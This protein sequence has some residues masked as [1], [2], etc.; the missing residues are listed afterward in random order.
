MEEPWVKAYAGGVPRHLD[1]EKVA[2]PQALS[3]TASQFP[4]LPALIFLDSKIQYRQLNEMATRFANA[5]VDFGVKRG[6]RVAML[7]PNMPQLVAATYGAW[8]MGAVVVMNNPLYTDSELEYQFRNSESTVLV[9][10]DL[11][12][13]RMIRLR[14]ETPIRKIIVAH[15]RDHLKFPKKQLLPI[16][17]R[18]KHRNI[19]PQENVHEW[20]DLMKR[21]PALEP[22]GEVDFEEL[23]CLQYTGGTTGV[24]KGVMLTHANLSLNTQQIASWFP[25]F[26]RGEITELG[27]L[28]FFHVFGLTA[29][30]NI[31]VWMAWTDVLIPRPEPQAIL[32]AIHKWKV[33]FFP[34]VPT[35]YVG[36]LRHPNV[37]KYSLDS[38]KGCFSGAAPLPVEVIQ[39][40]ESKTGSQICEGY[41]LSE[42]SPVATLNPFGGKTKWGSIG[43]PVPDTDVRI[44]DLVDG[45]REMPVGEA[46]EIIIRGPQVATGYFRMAEETANAFRDGWLF[47]GDIGTMDEEGYFY[48]VDRKKDM[49][50]AG[51]FNIYPREIDEVLFAH[52]KIAEACAVGIP[53]PYRGETIKA[54]VVLKTGEAMTA[55]EVIQH[56]ATKLARYKIPKS[57]EFMSA[58]PKS[59]VGKV[60]RKKLRAMEMAKMKAGE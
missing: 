23:A 36:V 54:F 51:G 42:T 17:A 14:S 50:I 60:L 31:C 18:D 33:N 40:F 38:I 57:V 37:A 1:Y 13:P 2:M 15:I 53:D 12:A 59:G 20:L 11:L 28:P 43:V 55:E 47:T 49:V 16:L 6:D 10:I 25:T 58:L 21:Y 22:P 35:M 8:R 34:G 46:G 5:L 4:D 30:M 24:S 29:C 52:P 9:T 27:A 45:T 32:E 56:C 26:K 39:E 41:G 48:I 3:R 19:S 44:V 7:M